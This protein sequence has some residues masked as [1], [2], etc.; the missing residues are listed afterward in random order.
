MG[1][2]K[3]LEALVET[4][5]FSAVETALD[6]VKQ[7]RNPERVQVEAW[8]EAQDRRLDKISTVLG[9]KALGLSSG[10]DKF[11]KSRE[12]FPELWDN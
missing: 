2:Q 5:G 12:L 9:I 8:I 10:V 1:C 3:I 7:Q 6:A 11:Q 4:F